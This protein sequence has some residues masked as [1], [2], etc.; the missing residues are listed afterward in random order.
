MNLKRKRQRTGPHKPSDRTGVT[1]RRDGQ[2]R[3]RKDRADGSAIWGDFTVPMKQPKPRTKPSTFKSK[4]ENAT[5]EDAVTP[6]G[7]ARAFF[8]VNP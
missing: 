7:F 1:G 5:P 6:A 3:G 8:E 4:Q 2:P